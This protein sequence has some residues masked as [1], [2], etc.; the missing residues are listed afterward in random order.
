MLEGRE[1]DTPIKP[2]EYLRR[3][4]DHDNVGYSVAQPLLPKETAMPDHPQNQPA[5]QTGQ[6]AGQQQPPPGQAQPQG[7]QPQGGQDP[8]AQQQEAQ[9]QQAQQAQAQLD[10]HAQTVADA[11]KQQSQAGP[12]P[13]GAGVDGGRLQQILGQ[14]GTYGPFVLQFLEALVSKL[15]GGSQQPPQG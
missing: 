2:R 8:Q 15:Q 1:P 4:G 5:Q 6:Q 3:H 10:Q 12:P 14:V 13:A 7:Q 9:A 11:I